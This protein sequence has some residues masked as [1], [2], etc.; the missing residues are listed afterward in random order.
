MLIS[1]SFEVELLFQGCAASFPPQFGSWC[2]AT[3]FLL[4]GA[5]FPPFFFWWWCFLLFGGC[6][7]SLPSLVWCCL[8]ASFCGAGGSFLCFFLLCFLQCCSSTVFLAFFEKLIPH[9]TPPSSFPL[10]HTPR[11][12]QAPPPKEDFSKGGWGPNPKLVAALSSRAAF[13]GDNCCCRIQRTSS[14]GLAVRF[15]LG[16][17]R[18]T[19]SCV[20]SWKP[21]IRDSRLREFIHGF[22]LEENALNISAFSVSAVALM[23]WT[24][25]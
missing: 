23:V 8:P 18:S 16:R 12:T 21:H 6:C 5:A 1:S 24:T 13:I 25:I 15:D 4:G 22:R 9:P 19:Q 7:L 14:T 17:W 2:F 11:H 3:S 20:S 10:P